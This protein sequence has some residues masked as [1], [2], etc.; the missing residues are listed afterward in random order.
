MLAE[1]FI[2]EN[3]LRKRLFPDKW[4][5]TTNSWRKPSLIKRLL[6]AVSKVLNQ[7]GKDSYSADGGPTSDETWRAFD[8]SR[9]VAVD[10]ETGLVTVSLESRTPMEAAVW[11]QMFIR[12][13]NEYI[14][15]KEIAEGQARLAYL[16]NQASS[17]TISEVRDAISKLMESELKQSMLANV[18]TEFAFKTIDP[19]VKPETQAWP[20]RGLLVAA[21][22]IAGLMLGLFIILVSGYIQAMRDARQE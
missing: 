14:R 19:A 17:T 4:D 21:G 5:E 13:A 3:D 12:H 20:K 6:I 10:K 16:S 22:L 11:T 9:T 8:E 18:R 2:A 15:T 1:A 7:G